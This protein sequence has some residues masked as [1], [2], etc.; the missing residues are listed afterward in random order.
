M[1]QEDNENLKPKTP[2]KESAEIQIPEEDFSDAHSESD[3]EIEAGKNENA[4]EFDEDSSDLGSTEEAVQKNILTRSNSRFFNKEKLSNPIRISERNTVGDSPANQADMKDAFIVAMISLEAGARFYKTYHAKLRRNRLFNAKVFGRVDSGVQEELVSYV[5]YSS[6]DTYESAFSEILKNKEPAHCVVVIEGSRNNFPQKFCTQDGRDKSYEYQLHS[7]S[8]SGQKRDGSRDDKQSMS[9]YLRST[10]PDI[11]FFNE[12]KI[13]CGKDD[14]FVAAE[15]I[16][17]TEDDKKF[18]ILFV[19]IPNRFTKT[20]GACEKVNGYIME[21]AKTR[22]SKDG[23]VLLAYYGDTNFKQ[24]MQ[25]NG[26]PSY[27]GSQEGS[28]VSPTS[29]GAKSPTAF[30]QAS[31]LIKTKSAIVKQPSTLNQ[32]N[33]LAHEKTDHISMAGSILVDAPIKREVRTSLFGKSKAEDE[34]QLPREKSAAEKP[35]SP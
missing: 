31:T 19:H 33:L 30:M 27:G 6:Q 20:Q 23:V 25:K 32:V 13:P 7:F 22:E 29:S 5:N 21:Y 10:T 24:V 26:R 11:L 12:V 2:V 15:A 8:I 16:F 17:S 1:R 34:N 4:D 35:F 18:G 3:S 14:G 9:F 28:Y